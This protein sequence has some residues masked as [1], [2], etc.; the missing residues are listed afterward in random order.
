MMIRCIFAFCLVCGLGGAATAQTV[1]SVQAPTGVAVSRFEWH[2]THKAERQNDYGLEKPGDYARTDPLN[3]E[4]QNP[5]RGVPSYDAQRLEIPAAS[6]RSPRRVSTGY[7]SSLHLENTGTKTITA[8]EWEHV[9]FT[10]KDKQKESRRYKFRKEIKIEPGK[11]TFVAQRIHS[12]NYS[13]VPTRQPQKVVI[14]R[15]EYSD[16][17]V[18]QQE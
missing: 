17:S 11:E 15:I 7:Q 18:W 8:V 4:R 1:T 14:N 16:G 10:D 13:E 5:A 3:P 12:E 9:F 6:V 2:Q